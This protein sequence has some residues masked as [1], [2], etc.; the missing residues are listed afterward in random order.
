MIGISKLRHLLDSD[1][2][3]GP[4]GIYFDSGCEYLG[5]GCQCRVELADKGAANHDVYKQAEDDQQENHP[6]YYAA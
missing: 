5:D 1:F 2:N 6:A 4:V 3:V